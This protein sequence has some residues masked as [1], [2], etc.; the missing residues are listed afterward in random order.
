MLLDLSA[1]LLEEIGSTLAHNDHAN[2]RA[3]CKDLD[4][5]MRR[6]FFSVLVLTL[7]EHPKRNDFY[8]TLLEMIRTLGTCKTGWSI[9]A[10]ML[11]IKRGRRSGYQEVEALPV[12]NDEMKDLLAFA[13]RSIPKIRTVVWEVREQAE[14]NPSPWEKT[15]GI[16]CEFLNTLTGLDDLQLD[17]QGTVDVSSLNVRSLRKFTL[18]SPRWER[19]FAFGWM[20]PIPDPTM[21]A[22]ISQLVA[23]N[24][25]SSLHLQGTNK[26]SKVWHTLRT[27]SDEFPIKLTEITTNVVTPEL[28]DYL[29]SYSG[30]EKLTLLYPDGGSRNDSDRLADIFFETVLPPSCDISGGT[31]LPSGLRKQSLEM[32]INAGAVREVDTPDVWIDEDGTEIPVVSIGVSVEAE[33]AD[34]DPVVTLL[35]ETAATLPFLCN[36]AIYSAET[37]SNRDARCGNGMINHTG[38]VNVAIEKAMQAFRSHMSCSAIVRAGNHTYELE[39]LSGP[40]LHSDADPKMLGYR[41]KGW[42]SRF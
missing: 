21:Y 37:E 8:P 13:L 31:L 27:K 24:Q 18:K 14:Q 20:T 15:N 36:L 25:L 38:A 33:Q 11:R 26:W 30:I 28:F 4:G 2:L 19:Q 12:S 1:E 10:R 16:I 3:V 40:D 32:S 35:L 7:G 9:H 42:F 6:L 39:P 29:S 17:V 34:I 41:Q 23:Q 5:A 22:D